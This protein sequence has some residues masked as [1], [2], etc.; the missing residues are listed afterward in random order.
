MP[1]PYSLVLNHA[2][3]RSAYSK[4]DPYLFDP[5]NVYKHGKTKAF[6]SWGY[7]VED[8]AWLQGEIE[9]QA[10]YKYIS[11]EYSLGRLNKDG[12]RIN[13]RI[14]IER[15]DGSGTV[16]FVSGWMVLPNGTIKLNTPY[17]GK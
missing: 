2:N 16:S 13:I 7:T 11:G 6:E 5:E 14:E 12:Q 4:F 10:L 1:L 9:Q 8:A 15:K 17:G 3:A